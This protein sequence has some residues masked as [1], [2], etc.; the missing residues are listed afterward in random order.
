MNKTL[1][2]KT[3]FIVAALL[4]LPLAQA[5]N[6]SKPNYQAAKTHVSADYKSD[7][8]A[9]A[10]FSAN[11]KDICIQQ[12]KAKEKVALAQL[13]FDYTHKPGDQTK[14]LVV[15]AETGYAVARE[16][17]DDKAGNDKAVCVKEAKA[18]KL[19]AL[20]D[21]KLGKQI[22]Q[23]RTDAAVAKRDADYKVDAVKC[24]A[25]AGDTKD[26]CIA[27]AKARFGKS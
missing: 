10:S 20:A 25:L 7:T 18:V 4:A 13:E 22:G 11:A 27:N 15:Q 14:L 23:A 6:M 26:A 21:A 16:Q 8:A 19:K 3:S 2:L 1:P 12:A 17:C 24:E 5:A 9:C